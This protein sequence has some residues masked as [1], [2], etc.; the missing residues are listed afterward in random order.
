LAKTGRRSL[1]IQLGYAQRYACNKGDKALY[2]KLINEVLSAEDPDPKLRLQNTIA[3][4]KAKRA[5]NSAVM[6]ECGF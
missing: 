6:A 4:R 3:K 2:E 1:F 5:L